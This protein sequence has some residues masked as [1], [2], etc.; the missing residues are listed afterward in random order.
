MKKFDNIKAIVLDKDGVFID[1][2][3][4]WMRIIAARAQILAEYT[5]GN[6]DNFN[7]VRTMC[8]RAM[9]VSEKDESIDA[10]SPVCMPADMVRMAVTTGLYLAVNS[11]DPDY[12]WAKAI[13]DVR[14]SDKDLAEQ[15]DFKEMITPIAGSIEKIKA[16]SKAGF[17]LALYTSDSEKNSQETMDKFE[18][19]GIFEASICG[20]YKTADLYRS[21]C[22]Q[23]KVK[24]SETIFITDSPV[25]ARVGREAGANVIAVLSGVMQEADK[26]ANAEYV[27]EFILSLADL[28]LKKIKQA[29]TV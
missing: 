5:T 15:L 4:L 20:R 17:K 11:L 9:G 12:T 18:I 21:I 24:E 23:L 25:D 19:P 8:I 29:A 6:W 3:Q 10:D 14:K 1:F 13:E 16:I 26:E 2:H 22:K 27:D 7:H 28:D